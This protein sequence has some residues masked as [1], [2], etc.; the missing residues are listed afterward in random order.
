MP[1]LAQEDLPKDSQ[2]LKTLAQH[3]RIEDRRR[4]QWLYAT[5]AS[6]PSWNQWARF[7]RVTRQAG[8]SAPTTTRKRWMTRIGGPSASPT[9]AHA[10]ARCRR[11][12]RESS[13][14]RSPLARSDKSFSAGS[15]LW[16][17]Y[18]A[19]ATA[20]KI[21]PLPADRSAGDPDVAPIAT[22]SLAY[23]PSPS[24]CNP[25]CK[26]SGFITGTSAHS[27]SCD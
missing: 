7:T 24:R 23:P 27:P 2:I 15:A 12:D 8:L 21:F 17:P 6:T 19:P 11:P 10:A 3:D 18:F 5:R 9:R 1:T 20:S 22:L 13:T 14:H 16:R 25:F 4:R 26:S